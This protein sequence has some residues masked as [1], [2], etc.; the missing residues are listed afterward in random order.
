V[1]VILNVEI[2]AGS[3]ISEAAG[4]MIALARRLG[5]MVESSFN[6]FDVLVHPNNN[7]GEIANQYFAWMAEKSKEY[8]A[9]HPSPTGE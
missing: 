7:A 1:L 9:A 6:G 5:V 4:H 3:E 2:V 8:R